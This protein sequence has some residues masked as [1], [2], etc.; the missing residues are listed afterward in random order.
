M[1]KT[2]LGLMLATGGVL[3]AVA[4]E[5][6][7]ASLAV[8]DIER[9]MAMLDATWEK[10]IRGTDSNLYMA[11]TYNTS[12][13]EVSGPSDIWPLT[14]AVEAHCS[15]L[16][17][18][19]MVKTLEPEL[20]ES[21]VETYRHRLELLIDNLEYYRG[22]Y[23][24]ASYAH[25]G[26]WSPYAVPRSGH[27]G[28]ANVTGI[29]NVY[30]DQMWLSRELIR[31]YRLT[32]NEVYLELATYL[33]DY[34][35]DGWDCWRDGNGKEYGGIT[36]GPGYNSKHAC[37]N[38]PIIQ[39]LVWLHDIYEGSGEQMDYYYRDESNKVMHEMRDRSELYLEFARKV[40]D[41][42]R[43]NLLNPSNLYYDM[44]GA[45]GTIKVSRGYRQHV[46]CGGPVGAVYSYNTG[47]MIGGGAELY[48]VTGEERY[49]TE[50]SAT[51][52]S[53]LSYF[54]S[55]KRKEGG[56]LFKTD[57]TAKSGFNT[58]FNNVLMRSYLDALPY[59]DNNSASNGLDGF[60]K[61]L[62][63]AYENYNRDGLLPIKLYDGWGDDV[64]TKGFHQFTFAGQYAL[65]AV[66]NLRALESGGVDNV[67]VS[68]REAA[69][70]TGVV[71][72]L[73]GMAL[74]KLDEVKGTLPRGLYVVDGRKVM[75]G[76]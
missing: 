9:S 29:L 49:R 30:D 27:R 4:A 75:M 32:D 35:L 2:I 41:W 61:F 7:D 66:R 43:E 14:A 62:D 54:A 45:D 57:E 6:G 12:T 17:A 72:N 73:S 51:S 1:K 3:P 20:Y 71:Y 22:T 21:N 10:T 50:V 5:T 56:Y 37:S 38:A 33:A 24:L 46:D 68:D 19:E 63:Y 44:K 60:Q 8:R 47:T 25:A 55:Y 34:V 69:P 76:E 59:V 67:T 40:Y 65:L 28:S 70:H 13:G 48:R 53:S 36:W 39:P 26:V 42:Q 58:W 52:K 11:D 74:G 23:T 31:A 18:L 16:E 64:V 15:V